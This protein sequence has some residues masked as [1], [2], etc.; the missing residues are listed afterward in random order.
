MI[1]MENYEGWLM[2]Y[3]DGALTRE[4]REAVEAFLEVHP[5][6]REELEEL[7]AV[8]VAPVVA[9]LPDKGRLLKKEMATFAWWRVAASVA[10]L[11]V[12]GSTLIIL[13]RKAEEQPL[14]AENREMD[15]VEAIE[16]LE[17]IDTTE[18]IGPESIKSIQSIPSIA[19]IPSPPSAPMPEE[20]PLLAAEESP[21]PIPSPESEETPRSEDSLAPSRQPV[22]T[23]TVAPVIEDARL[24]V[25]PWLEALMANR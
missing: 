23:V 16:G 12:A 3:A 13:N 5:D 15:L 18:T 6:L 22:P 7:S 4:E 21:Q 19:S 24:A 14:V 8:K 1:T 9:T 11:L 17:V 2:R 10:L 20:E 25:N